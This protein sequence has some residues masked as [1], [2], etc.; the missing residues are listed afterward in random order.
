MLLVASS[1]WRTSPTWISCSR[2]KPNTQIARLTV[3][4]IS[5]AI[6]RPRNVSHKQRYGTIAPS[7]MTHD[8]RALVPIASAAI[9]PLDLTPRQIADLDDHLV[10]TWLRSHR[11]EHTREAYAHDVAQFRAFV[12]K[13]LAAVGIDD[14]QDY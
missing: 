2:R 5:R 4:M 8:S 10:R 13:P 3:T 12:S 9:Q 7:S 1:Y 11:S 14:L 6:C